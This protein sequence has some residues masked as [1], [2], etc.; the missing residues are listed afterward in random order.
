M[1]SGYGGGVMVQ[2]A[3]A[4]LVTLSYCTR[5]SPYHPTTCPL[6]PSHPL[7]RESYSVSNPSIPARMSSPRMIRTQLSSSPMV[8]SLDAPW[9]LQTVELLICVTSQSKGRVDLLR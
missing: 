4:G 6:P 2:M 1:S 3:D 5:T 9:V 8:R 7:V